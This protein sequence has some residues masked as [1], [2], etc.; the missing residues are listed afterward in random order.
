[1]KLSQGGVLLLPSFSMSIA[2]DE[3]RAWRRS[4]GDDKAACNFE[5]IEKKDLFVRK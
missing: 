4:G 1:M 2:C 5:G 3:M